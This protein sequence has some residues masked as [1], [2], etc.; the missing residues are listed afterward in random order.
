M[1]LRRFLSSKFADAS[2]QL[3]DGST[4]NCYREALFS[5]SKL[6]YKSVWCPFE[7]LI[8]EPKKEKKK[9]KKNGPSIE[10]RVY[11]YVFELS[12][13]FIFLFFGRKIIQSLVCF[14]T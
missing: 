2:P 5:Y 11:S 14:W 3:D 1:E 12:G 9:R 13:V 7:I 4:Q 8:F 6:S 10:F